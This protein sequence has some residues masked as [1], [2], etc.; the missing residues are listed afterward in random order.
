MSDVVFDNLRKQLEL[1]EWP[2]VFMFKFIV[3]NDSEKVAKVTSLFDDGAD[4]RYQQSKTG[5]YVSVSAKELM[6]DV[7][8]I[9]VKYQSA[10]AIDG[11]IAL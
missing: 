6:V 2:D 4:L 8:S 10:A 3:P 11:V 7:D 9:I 1:Q 5:K